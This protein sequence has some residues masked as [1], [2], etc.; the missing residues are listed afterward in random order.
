MMMMMMMMRRM[1]MMMMMIMINIWLSSLFPLSFLRRLCLRKLVSWRCMQGELV[2]WRYTQYEFVSW[3]GPNKE[4]HIQGHISTK[5]CHTYMHTFR[6][7]AVWVRD[8]TVSEKKKKEQVPAPLR[9]VRYT[10]H[11]DTSLA[12]AHAHI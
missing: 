11:T 3:R 7:H 2:S 8:L 4:C 10:A 12:P 1:M 5:R 9:S 6:T